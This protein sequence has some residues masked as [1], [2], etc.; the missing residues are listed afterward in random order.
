MGFI[1]FIILLHCYLAVPA[2][3]SGPN[4]PERYSNTSSNTSDMTKTYV[5]QLIC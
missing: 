3:H 4:S 5:I 2:S 1:V